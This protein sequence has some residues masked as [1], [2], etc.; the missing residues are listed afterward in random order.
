MIKNA[1]LIDT[2]ALKKQ[3]DVYLECLHKNLFYEAHEAL[4]EIWFPLR[5]EK[6]EEV[7]LVR[8]YINAA[9][10]FE[11]VKRGREKAG[12]KP[13]SFFNR[14]APLIEKVPLEHQKIYQNIYDHILMTQKR[15]NCF[16]ID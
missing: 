13:W 6:D 9:V 5:F 11:L 1:S 2:K 14:Y 10:S 15:L 7:R 16:L 4:E 12:L 8:A 3:H